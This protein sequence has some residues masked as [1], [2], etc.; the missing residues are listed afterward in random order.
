VG[1]GGFVPVDREFADDERIGARGNLEKPGVGDGAELL[2]L[3]RLVRGAL[4]GPPTTGDR[5]LLGLS[6]I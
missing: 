5:A 1:F 6:Q 4:E 3:E 2:Q